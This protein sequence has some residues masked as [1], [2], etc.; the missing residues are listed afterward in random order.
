MIYRV[1]VPTIGKQSAHIVEVEASS[2]EEA[3]QQAIADHLAQYEGWLRANV[4]LAS[5]GDGDER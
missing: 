3:L 1:L 2:R 5:Q 4:T